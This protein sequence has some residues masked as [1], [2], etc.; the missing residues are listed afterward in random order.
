MSTTG[1]LTGVRIGVARSYYEPLADSMVIAAMDNAIDV[2]R[3]L[4]ATTVD[5]ETMTGDC[6]GA[7]L[8]SPTTAKIATQVLRTGTESGRGHHLP[9]AA[10]PIG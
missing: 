4:G 7:Q 5:V 1:D 2:L 6:C 3:S 10:A 9:I 8:D